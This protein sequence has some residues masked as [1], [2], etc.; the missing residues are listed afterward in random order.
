MNILDFSETDTVIDTYIFTYIKKLCID[1]GDVIID[2]YYA[3]TSYRKNSEYKIINMNVMIDHDNE[4][5]LINKDL[6]YVDYNNLELNIEILIYI[7]KKWNI[8]TDM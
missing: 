2:Y 8:T 7:R 3:S 4:K 5:Y 6:S 1:F